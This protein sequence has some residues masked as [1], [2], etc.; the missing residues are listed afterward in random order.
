MSLPRS[1]TAPSIPWRCRL[2]SSPRT[3]SQVNH[4]FVTLLAFDSCST[5]KSFGYNKLLH[6]FSCSLT[7][8]TS[9]KLITLNLDVFIKFIHHKAVLI[10]E[11]SNICSTFHLLPHSCL[12]HWQEWLSFR[13]SDFTNKQR[14]TPTPLQTHFWQP[15]KNTIPTW[16][17]PLVY[18]SVYYVVII[19]YVLFSLKMSFKIVF[20]LEFVFFC[21][22]LAFFCPSLHLYWLYFFDICSYLKQILWLG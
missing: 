14:H 1:P 12:H 6:F 16:R 13:C 21:F 10:F 17:L 8:H 3:S 22:F 11:E 18:W 19:I 7:F 20:Q 15:T 4:L 5:S 2:K 9:T